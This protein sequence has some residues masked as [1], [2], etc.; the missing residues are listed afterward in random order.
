MPSI[1]GI[2]RISFLDKNK[3]R[4]F[5]FSCY[6]AGVMVCVSERLCW[7]FNVNFTVAG[8]IQQSVMKC[9]LCS[10]DGLCHSSPHFCLF[11][12]ILR[13]VAHAVTSTARARRITRA[14]CTQMFEQS[15]HVMQ[16]LTTLYPEWRWDIMP[17]NELCFSL[18][19]RSSPQPSRLCLKGMYE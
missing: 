1:P 17:I 10:C 19:L 15:Y 14:S 9:G 2:T 4:V 11:G 16:Y 8:V 18:K 6:T 3:N 5:R 12:L 13:S 7:S